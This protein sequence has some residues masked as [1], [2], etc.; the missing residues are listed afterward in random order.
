MI[1]LLDSSAFSHAKEIGRVNE[2][3]ILPPQ[4]L[5]GGYLMAIADGVGSYTGADQASRTA[6]N[7]IRE[8]QSHDWITGISSESIFSEIKRR[9]SDLSIQDQ[10]ISDAATTL[11]FCYVNPHGIRIGHIG[12]CRAYIRIGMSLK[13]LTVDHTQ[14]QRLMDEGLYRAHELK[15]LGGKNTL[16]SAISKKLELHYQDLWLPHSDLELHNSEIEIVLMSDGAHKVWDMRPRFAQSTMSDPNK[17]ASSL[18]KRINWAGPT[19]DY[20]LVSSK[21]LINKLM[22]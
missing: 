11:T 22:A 10:N 18:K 20:S 4:L 1:S 13:Q 2:D 19:D 14:H 12:D 9:I 5:G 8:I 3:A 21:F 16:F 7:Y 6:I 17:F 15:L